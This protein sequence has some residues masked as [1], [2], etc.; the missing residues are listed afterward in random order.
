ME[1]GR[2][3]IIMILELL[4]AAVSSALMVGHGLSQMEVLGGCL[5]IAA[6]LLEA[7]GGGNEG[8]LD[9]SMEG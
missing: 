9:A 4:G 3:S 6:S 1:A 7:R 5:I 8:S 2:S